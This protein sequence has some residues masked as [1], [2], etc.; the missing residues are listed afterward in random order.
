M[1]V[2]RFNELEHQG[3]LDRGIQSPG[4]PGDDVKRG[5]DYREC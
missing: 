5:H 2:I 3:A 1:W 4:V